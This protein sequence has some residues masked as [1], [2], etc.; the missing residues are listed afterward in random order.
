MANNSY[1]VRKYKEDRVRFNSAQSHEASWNTTNS[2]PKRKKINTDCR[3]T[4]EQA[5]QR[6]CGISILG[7]IQSCAGHIP[8]QPATPGYV[9]SKALDKRLPEGLEKSTRFCDSEKGRN[10]FIYLF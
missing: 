9:L 7:D 6:S 2:V 3:H 4:L 1:L 5:A 8:E 10:D